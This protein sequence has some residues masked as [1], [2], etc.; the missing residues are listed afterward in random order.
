MTTDPVCAAIAAQK[1]TLA[2]WQTLD[3]KETEY[4]RA[5]HADTEAV[6]AMIA[7]V[8]TT[9]AGLIALLSYVLSEHGRGNYILDEDGLLELIKTTASSLAIQ[10]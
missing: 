2:Y 3:E 9:K 10:S 6:D 4:D 5:G 1:D 8:P 7:T